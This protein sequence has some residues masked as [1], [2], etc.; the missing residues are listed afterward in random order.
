[1]GTDERPTWA[2]LV[3]DTEI[4]ELEPNITQNPKVFTALIRNLLYSFLRALSS[5]DYETAKDLL[6]EGE[7]P[8]T[9]SN[10]ERAFWPFFEE[11]MVIAL[12]ATGRSPSNTVIDASD[13]FWKVNQNIVVGGE[14]SEYLIRGRVDLARSALEKRPVFLLDFA[15]AS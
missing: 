14:I 4:E 13:D 11:G 9:A 12:D 15:G 8:I 2:K 7:V 5:R 1:M 3:R 10:L 6:D